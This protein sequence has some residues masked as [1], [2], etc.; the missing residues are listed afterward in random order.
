[1]SRVCI[2]SDLEKGSKARGDIAAG[3]EEFDHWTSPGFVWFFQFLS[4]IQGWA[5][6][7]SLGCM[8]S[9]PVAGENQEAGFTQPRD[10]SLPS[11][12]EG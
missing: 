1:M 3:I 2:D 11:P 10:H 7:W 6:E 8:N 5:K 12:V 4:D 9:R